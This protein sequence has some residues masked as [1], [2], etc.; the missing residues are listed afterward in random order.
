MVVDHRY[1]DPQGSWLGGTGIQGMARIS[2]SAME[3]VMGRSAAYG[4]AKFV[5][6][7]VVVFALWVASIGVALSHTP[8]QHEI[9]LRVVVPGV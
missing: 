3:M 7:W 1:D 5:G 9:E 6:L 2:Y 4:V 8:M